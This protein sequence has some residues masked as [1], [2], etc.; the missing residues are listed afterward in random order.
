VPLFFHKDLRLLAGRIMVGSLGAL[1]SS[2]IVLL[3]R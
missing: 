2:F 1:V 3:S